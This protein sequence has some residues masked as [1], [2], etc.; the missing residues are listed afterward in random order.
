MAITAWKEKHKQ[1]TVFSHAKVHAC[2]SSYV[3][4]KCYYMFRVIACYGVIFFPNSM[5]KGKKTKKLFV[6][7]THLTK[8]ISQENK[9]KEDKRNPR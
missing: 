4:S 2:R 8:K 9:D 5:L 7:N 1:V 6:T 3:S